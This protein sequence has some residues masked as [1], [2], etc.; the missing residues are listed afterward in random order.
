MGGRFA[1]T[2][3]RVVGAAALVWGLYLLKANVWFRLYPAV[4]VAVAFSLFASS[5]VFGTPLAERFARRMGEQLDERGVAYCRKATVAW[6]VFL[7]IHLAVTLATVFCASRE[8]WAFY[9]G[10]LAYVL[11]GLMF[12]G[13]WLVRRRARRG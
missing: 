6:T 5:L 3:L 8:V 7:A 4:V 2:A 9:N 1:K 11:I 13:E 12:A 10:C